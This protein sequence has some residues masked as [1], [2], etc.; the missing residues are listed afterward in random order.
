[1]QNQAFM[2]LFSLGEIHM[3]DLAQ[4][5]QQWLFEEGKSTKTIESYVGNLQGFQKHLAERK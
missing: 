4:A 3:N 1:M 5:F 2:A